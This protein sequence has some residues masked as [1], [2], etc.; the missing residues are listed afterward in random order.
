MIESK[1][2]LYPIHKWW[3]LLVLSTVAAGLASF[4]ATVEQPIVYQA[5]TTLMIGST[6]SDPNPSSAEFFL[7]QQLAVAYADIANRDVVRNATM[8]KLGLRRLPQYTARALENTQLIEILVTDVDPQR[9]QIVANELAEQ[10]ILLSPTN[11]D[12]EEQARLEFIND[13]LTTLEEQIEDTQTE[14]DALREKLGELVTAQEITDTQTQIDALEGKLN[15]LQNNYAALLQNTNP[16]AINTLSIIEPAAIPT[17]P[18]GPDKATTILLS[19]AVGLVLAVSAAFI[20]EYVLDSSLRFPEEVEFNLQA[21]IIGHIFEAHTPIVNQLLKKGTS[22]DHPVP[23][24]I[25][26]MPGHPALE[27]YQTLKINLRFAKADG[28]LNT[29]LVGGTEKQDGSPLVATNLAISMAEEGKQIV[30]LDADLRNPYLHEYF[31]I[32]N[33]KGLSELLTHKASVDA[34]LKPTQ[35]E[36]LSIVPAGNSPGYPTDFLTFERLDDLLAEMRKNA[37]VLIIHSPPFCYAEA[38]VLASKTDG[39]LV[40]IRPGVTK[41]AAAKNMADQ[42][43]MAH[44]RLLGV[45]LN[46]IPSWGASY[47][48]KVSP[49]GAA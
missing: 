13:Q 11:L 49:A 25:S 19:A 37:D 35:I 36:G 44:A 16:D 6:I 12:P 22:S 2:F 20:L 17:S 21:P 4:F 41:K 1:K 26:Q 5:R 9:A 47:F 28:E 40:V 43:D 23:L 24:L 46:R 45:V 7:G 8:E 30:L 3:W 32:E 33:E 31:E 15:S 18:I 29:I 42:I 38:S 10:L 34:V 27:H 14:L 48:A 39:V